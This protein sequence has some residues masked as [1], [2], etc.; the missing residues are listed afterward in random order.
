MSAAEV[1]ELT[2]PAET[3][4]FKFPTALTVLAM[5]LVAVWLASFLIP[6]GIYDLDPVTNSPIPGTYHELPSCSNATVGV[7][8]IDKSLVE[9]F[10]K[11]WDATPSGLYGVQNAKG[12]VGADEE[13]ILYGSAQIFLF[14]LAIGAFITVTMKTGAIE[15]G[16]GRLAMRFRHSPALLGRRSSCWSSR[17][18]GPRYGMWEETLGFFALLVPLALALKYDRVVAVSM[19]L[20]WAPGTG[21]VCFYRQPIRDRRRIGCRRHQHQRR[22]RPAHRDVARPGAGGHRLRALVRQPCPQGPVEINQRRRRQ[23]MQ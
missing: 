4:R 1:A 8:C 22:H 6:S 15:N 14:V 9:Q 20:A 7:P 10:K 13:G 23:R 5:V 3:H 16:I 11:L 21:V 2:A 18:A 17:S 19:H 12:F